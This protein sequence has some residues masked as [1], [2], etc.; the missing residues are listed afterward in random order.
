MMSGSKEK[1]TDCA[2][3]I[4]DN[5]IE[6]AVPVPSRVDSP[7]VGNALTLEDVSTLDMTGDIPIVA[8]TDPD[9]IVPYEKLPAKMKARVIAAYGE[10][11][12]KNKVWTV[13]IIEK[14]SIA[15]GMPRANMTSNIAQVCG[16]NC[17]YKDMCVHNILGVQPIGFRCPQELLLMKHLFDEYLRAVATRLDAEEEELRA[18]IIYHNLIM[19]LVESDIISMRLDGSLASEGFITESVSAINEET[20]DVFYKEE[21]AVAIRI[22][23]RVH[24]RKDQLYRQLIATPEMAEK[25]KKKGSLDQVSRSADLLDRM[26]M[27]LDKFEK[28]HVIDAEVISE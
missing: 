7:S 3:N 28:K 8:L 26:D 18:D 14:L 15:L 22:K 11:F 17:T 6:D 23:E 1:Q 9:D 25:Y 19:G 13:G 5:P 24:R 16:P 27:L 4:S 2:E 10:D 21:E 20:G 12:V